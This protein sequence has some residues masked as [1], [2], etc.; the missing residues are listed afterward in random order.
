MTPRPWIQRPAGAP[1]SGPAR[2]DLAA[3]NPPGRRPAL[4]VLSLCIS[5]LLLAGFTEPPP[6]PR[7]LDPIEA[8]RQGRELVAEIL[9]Q[10]PAQNFTNSG[11]LKTR[12][13]KGLRKEIPIE[14]KI[15]ITSETNWFSVYKA[16][17][18]HDL[19]SNV[20][21]GLT[22]LIKIIHVPGRLN[23]YE[24][25]DI[26]CC[27]TTN[28]VS[29]K[30]PGIEVGPNGQGT[31]LLSGAEAMLPFAGSDFWLADL[32][33]EFFHWPDQKLLKSEL[34]KTHL[35]RVLESTNPQPATNAYSRVVSWID[36][37]S[38]GILH[39]EAYD[40][41]NRLLKEFDTKKFKKVNG[42]WQL[43][44]MEIYNV[45]SRSRTQIEFNFDSK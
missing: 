27:V 26:F 44:Q 41:Q 6:Q 17:L 31:S 33:L 10:R 12:D 5:V 24:A 40:S 32:G 4:Q 36:D 39:A 11:V 22:K 20:W 19:N 23:Q 14:F 1:A 18:S 45:Q 38:R 42:D 35:C 21:H 7:P 3:A 29:G 2:F 34:R 43:E 13:V 28:K 15:L 9:S 8:A 30:T 37:E 16:D 25:T